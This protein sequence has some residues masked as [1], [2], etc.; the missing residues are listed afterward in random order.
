MQH[1]IGLTTVAAI[2]IA[3]LHAAPAHA[4]DWLQFGQDTLHSSN[5]REEK[6][7]ST[8]G[9]K[10]AYP[11]VT[12]LHKADSAPIFVEGVVTND[13]VKDLL[14]INALDGTLTAFDAAN[15][16]II[17]SHQPTPAAGAGTGFSQGGTTGSPAID[18]SGCTRTR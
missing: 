16:N 15:G 3:A 10:L 17:W 2:A 12:L 8:T 1:K 5:N 18:S 9:N 11:A 14:F 6:G 13:G 7:Y 4:T